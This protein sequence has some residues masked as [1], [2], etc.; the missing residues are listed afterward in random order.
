MTLFLLN[1]FLAVL[2]CLTWGA[3]N[4]YMLLSGFAFGYLILGVYSRVTSVEG[5]GRKVWQLLRF[6]AYFVRL[7]LVANLQ[8]AKEILSPR[9]GQ[10]PRIVRLDVK[11]LTP[12]QRT[13]L[14]NVITLTPGSLVVDHSPERD[15]LYVHCMYARDRDATVKQLEALKSRLMSEVF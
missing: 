6:S 14:S 2:W 7:L 8:I 11:D 9:F 10:T 13:V 4:F 3:F 15:V 5:Y 12:V 1:I